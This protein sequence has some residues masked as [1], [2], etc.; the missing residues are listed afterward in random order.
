MPLDEALYQKVV[1]AMEKRWKSKE[2]LR[3]ADEYPSI[4]RVPFGSYEL[5]YLSGRGCPAKRV[6]R[7]WGGES[8]GK[9]LVA[10]SVARNA[11]N[12]HIIVS[13]YYD[14]LAEFARQDGDK[15]LAKELIAVRD[16]Y[17]K[18]WPEGMDVVYYNVE[19]TFDE[20]FVRKAGLDLTRVKLLDDTVIETVGEGLENMIDAGADLHIID[21]TTSAIPLDELN[22]ETTEHRRGLE[23]RRWSLMLRRAKQRM[24]SRENA[25]II[26][27]SQVR[28]DQKTNSEYPPGG[29]Y[30]DHAADLSIHFHR[31][32]WLW[33]DRNGILRDDSE[34]QE[35]ASLSGMKEPDGVEVQCRAVKSRVCRPFLTGRSR[36]Q[37]DGMKIDLD[38][39]LKEAA[40]YHG[41]VPKSAAGGW[42][43]LP[44][45]SKVQGEAKL[46]Q[47]IAADLDLKQRIVDTWRDVTPG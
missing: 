45:G 1:T 10:W 11:Q 18:I 39:E 26:Y 19:Q 17:L 15:R 24:Q 25:M 16:S 12:I 30:M 27:I 7:L 5:D 34:D 46:R 23:A 29:K 42:Y 2:I 4:K 28:I 47:A 40:V 21:S 38:Y 13:E 43:T 8:S 37:F 6:T 32:K 22:M 36:L 9:S 44:D 20:D 33:K 31:G 14:R 41:I 3:R 35:V